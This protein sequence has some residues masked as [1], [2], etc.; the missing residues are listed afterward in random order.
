MAKNETRR[1]PAPLLKEDGKCVEKISTLEDYKPN[2]AAHSV[3]QLEASRDAVNDCHGD[4]AKA[5]FVLKS[6][7]NKSI[8][9][10]WSFHKKVLGAK[11]QVIAQYGEDSDQVKAVGLKKKSEYKD[12]SKS[13]SRSANKAA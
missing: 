1:V 6:A 11:K 12:R 7:R 2:N 3:S 5:E 9:A 8:K 13:K 4:E 10:E